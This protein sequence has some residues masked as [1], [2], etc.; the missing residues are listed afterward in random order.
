MTGS[1]KGGFV[2][3]GSFMKSSAGFFLLFSF[4]MKKCLIKYANEISSRIFYSGF[5]EFLFNKSQFY[6]S[7]KWM[8]KKK[9][10]YLCWAW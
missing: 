2:G 6:S 5:I 9:N 10:Q 3:D 8:R 4:E 7:R 1:R